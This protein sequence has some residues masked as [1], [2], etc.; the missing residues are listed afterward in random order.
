MTSKKA[1]FFLCLFLLSICP[2]KAMDKLLTAMAAGTSPSASTQ[3]TAVKVTIPA[4]PEDIGFYR[5]SAHVTPEVRSQKFKGKYYIDLM[6]F[7]V[8]TTH[9]IAHLS[10]ENQPSLIT[11][12]FTMDPKES[13]LPYLS[14]I[15][16]HQSL[17]GL[18]T[19][20]YSSLG[21]SLFN[22]STSDKKRIPKPE[23]TTPDSPLPIEEDLYSME[24]EIHAH[25]P[26]TLQDILNPKDGKPIATT[27]S[28][29][30]NE[31]LK[32]AI[33]I[34][35]K[36]NAIESFEENMEKDI[37]EETTAELT[38]KLLSSRAF[39]FTM[40][41]RNPR[42]KGVT[43]VALDII[44]YPQDTNYFLP[45]FQGEIEAYIHTHFLRLVCT[46]I[47]EFFM[48]VANDMVLATPSQTIGYYS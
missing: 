16:E 5:F 43:T 19:F 22:K 21:Q 35:N 47:S 17:K 34:Q 24:N 36:R 13:P 29:I 10:P 44:Q 3:Q 46:K 38:R 42:D 18:L 28:I 41:F 8:K 12:T 27:P 9:Q 1:P 45:I 23:K 32:L 31:Q 6:D 15:S 14:Y 39:N 20:F 48:D 33:T 30:D 11:F 26:A 25:Y 4:F 7:S 40:K 2:V 37:K